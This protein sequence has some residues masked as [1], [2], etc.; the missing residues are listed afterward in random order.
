MRWFEQMPRSLL[1]GIF[2]SAARYPGLDARS[3]PTFQN[4]FGNSDQLPPLLLVA[5][6]VNL[7]GTT[8]RK[9]VGWPARVS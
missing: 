6:G 7:T 9:S 2:T 1:R 4:R 5:G 3:G 8:T